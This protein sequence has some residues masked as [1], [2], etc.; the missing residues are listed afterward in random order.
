MDWFQSTPSWAEIRCTGQAVACGTLRLGGVVGAVFEHTYI[1]YLRGYR[2]GLSGQTDPASGPVLNLSLRAERLASWCGARPDHTPW[3]NSA[4]GI[5][6]R[7][8]LNN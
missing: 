5:L 6:P 1:M 4:S 7:V 8:V 2:I 3:L